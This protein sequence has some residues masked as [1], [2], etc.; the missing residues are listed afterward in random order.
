MCSC[1]EVG[2]VCVCLLQAVSAVT[3]PATASPQNLTVLPAAVKPAETPQRSRRRDSSWQDVS[4]Q[5]SFTPS[6]K[7]KLHS[8]TSDPMMLSTEL[9]VQHGGSSPLPSK[10]LVSAWHSVPSNRNMTAR[11]PFSDG[12]D[13]QVTNLTDRMHARTAAKI[14][15]DGVAKPAERDSPGQTFQVS[16]P[17]A[18]SKLSLQRNFSPMMLSQSSWSSRGSSPC[19]SNRS[20]PL[21][22]LSPSI[23]TDGP[24]EPFSDGVDVQVTNLDYRMSRKDLQQ[25]LRDTFAKHGRVKSVDLSPH[26][27]YQL[28]ARVH[29][30]S[31]QQAIGAVSLLQRYKIGSKR[32]HVSLVTG[33]SNKSLTCLSSEIISILQDAPANCLPLYKFTETYER[34]FGHKLVVSDLYRLPEVVCVREQGGGRLVCL[35][36]ST[37][38]RQSPLGSAHSHNSS[39]TASPVLFEE[40]EYHEP[41]CR[42]H[43]TQQDFS[44]SDFDPDSYVIPFVLVSLKVLAAHVH[45]LLQSHEGTVPLLR[46]THCT[47]PSVAQSAPEGPVP[48]RAEGSAHTCALRVSRAPQGFC[49]LHRAQQH[50]FSH[51][52]TCGLAGGLPNIS[53]PSLCATVLRGDCRAG[54]RCAHSGVLGIEN[55]A[56]PC[57]RSAATGGAEARRRFSGTPRRRVICGCDINKQNKAVISELN[58]RPGRRNHI[59]ATGQKC[60]DTNCV[61]AS[62]RFERRTP[63]A[64]VIVFMPE[65]QFLV[66]HLPRTARRQS[67]AN[68]LQ[69]ALNNCWTE[70]VGAVGQL[71]RCSVRAALMR[72]RCTDKRMAEQI[73]LEHRTLLPS[74]PTAREE[75]RSRGLLPPLLFGF[76]PWRSAPPRRCGGVLAH[77]RA[78]ATPERRIAQESRPRALVEPCDEIPPRQLCTAFCPPPPHHLQSHASSSLP[79]SMCC[80]CPCL[81]S[82]PAAVPPAVC[83]SGVCCC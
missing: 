23:C 81:R 29:M 4:G 58:R 32:I 67:V 44:E 77:A 8:G 7:T 55:Y 40:L 83:D 56:V 26:T 2:A 43:C 24:A 17:S 57:G 37:Q 10:R 50:L 82:R 45:G 49:H 75:K 79:F 64:T 42:R 30:S 53:P 46:Q 11:E 80:R 15:R 1:V 25:I 68:R 3:R 76:L 31:L 51:E 28:K 39:N 36:S 73:V 66:A 22:T 34:K 71:R 9:M 69:R 52:F 12:G 48:L 38:A 41:V 5:H 72:L 63:L 70:G 60:T 35:L 61:R 19:L 13:V 16:T 78:E 65:L 27:D 54:A 33:A 62:G 21:S 47:P 59:S 74:S 14:L 6:S 18:F 20:S